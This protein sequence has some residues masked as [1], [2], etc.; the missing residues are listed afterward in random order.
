[1]SN[2]EVYNYLSS[3]E[4]P[5]PIIKSTKRFR[6]LRTILATILIAGTIFATTSCAEQED[7][8]HEFTFDF[9][10]E[11]YKIPDTYV[12]T[13]QGIEY[14]Y[15]SKN[16]VERLSRQALK[17]VD[18]L[19]HQVPNMSP[20]G[21]KTGSF[22][23]E[24]FNVHM[25]SAIAYT[26]STYRYIEADGDPLVSEDGAIG[27][28]QLTPGAIKT[29]NEWLSDT[30]ELDKQYTVE[31]ASD[32]LKSLELAILYNI[33]NSKNRLKE[34]KANYEKMGVKF[35][36]DLQEKLLYAMYFYGEGNVQIA[37]N[38]GKIF[39]TY[40]NPEWRD[41]NDHNYV[42]KVLENKEKLYGEKSI[43]D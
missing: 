27:M 30:M 6:P 4:Q 24:Y 8:D 14:R 29:I 42:N 16:Y 22:Y 43:I 9:S 15:C 23:P 12:D 26:E 2:K 17:N 19:M 32:P 18:K 10:D 21:T 7:I 11:G 40:L 37:I 36:L 5:K 1:M 33:R 34:G 35:S 25:L 39:D 13:Y 41:S 28:C 31:D 38:N 3:I 20:V